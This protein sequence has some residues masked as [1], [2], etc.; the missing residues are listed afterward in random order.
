MAEPLNPRADARKVSGGGGGPPIDVADAAALIDALRAENAGRTIHVRK[1]TYR[2][3][4]P[5]LVPD[6]AS[7]EGEG[8]MLGDDLP[9]GFEAGTETTI[10]AVRGTEGNLLTLGDRSSVQGLVLEAAAPFVAD[11]AG[12]GGNVVAVASRRPGDSVSAAIADCE[13]INQ[14]PSGASADGPVGGA[15]LAHTRNPRG[16]DPPHVDAVITVRVRRSRVSAPSGG[17]AVFAMNFAASGGVNVELIERTSLVVRWTSSA[18]FRGRTPSSTPE[19]RSGPAGIS[20]RSR[21]VTT[22]PGRSRVEVTRR[23]PVQARPP[24]RQVHTREATGSRTFSSES[25]RSVADD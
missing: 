8:V 10:T 3:N 11:A 17:K 1:G 5:L 4:V 2:V 14:N 23:S 6:G 9:A 7:L 12:R 22:P 24:T 15:L 13:L 21:G 19:P 18:D 16:A 25:S 20:S